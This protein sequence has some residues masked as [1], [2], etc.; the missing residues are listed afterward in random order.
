VGSGCSSNVDSSID[1]MK[2]GRSE[3]EAA[4]KKDIIMIKSRIHYE[5]K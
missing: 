1:G 2:K 3:S 4:K 5:N